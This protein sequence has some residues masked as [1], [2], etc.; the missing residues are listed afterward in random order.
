M[1]APVITVQIGAK[2]RCNRGCAGA[3]RLPKT[4]KAHVT[5]H[6]HARIAEVVLLECGHLDWHHINSADNP[7]IAWPIEAP[8]DD[9]LPQEECAKNAPYSESEL[10]DALT[11]LESAAADFTMEVVNMLKYN[12]GALKLLQKGYLPRLTRAVRKARLALQL[13]HTLE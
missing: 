3:Q 1:D 10:V 8:A 11:E 12:P 9:N 7:D 6:R 5:N 2:A 4:V 13:D